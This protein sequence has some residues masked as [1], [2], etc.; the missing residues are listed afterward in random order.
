MD[1][2]LDNRVLYMLR[3]HHTRTKKGGKMSNTGGDQEQVTYE[4]FERQR[5]E[6]EQF[7]KQVPVVSALQ[8]VAIIKEELYTAV[9]DEKMNYLSWNYS[10]VRQVRGDGNCFYRCVLFCLFEQCILKRDLNKIEQ[11]IGIVEQSLNKIVTDL[12][13]PEYTLQD[14]YETTLEFCKWVSDEL[15]KT[16]VLSKEDEDE[17]LQ[18]YFI[19]ITDEDLSSCLI[20]YSRFMLSHYLQTH[21]EDFEAFVYATE[22]SSL[23]QYCRNEIE[24]M[25]KDA[26]NIGITGFAKLWD[27]CILIEYIDV[28]QQQH[29]IKIPDDPLIEPTIY[30]L[31]R[32]GHYDILYK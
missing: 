1:L 9:Q 8:P 16:S 2:F 22:Y 19:R 4:D 31:F 32:P 15:K 17:L 7:Q 6:I 27:I 3:H 29:S 23:D 11:V 18:K 24:S 14:F 5:E 12:N 10:L 20:C 21:K 30:L 26:D 28:S 25:Y 13:Y